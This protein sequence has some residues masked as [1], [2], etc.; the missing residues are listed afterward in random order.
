VPTAREAGKTQ[1]DSLLESVRF[2]RARARSVYKAS[3]SRKRRS[4]KSATSESGVGSSVLVDKAVLVQPNSRK[5]YEI[6]L[7]KGQLVS[8]HARADYPITVELISRTELLKTERRELKT[9]ET[10]RSRTE[11]KTA[12][13]K[14]EAKRHGTW[15]VHIHNEQRKLPLEVGVT[16]SVG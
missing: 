3:G 7:R 8:I 1:P 13:I 14:Y 4:G 12:N 6:V 9:I 10:E 2:A 15:V 11:V 5:E 16:I